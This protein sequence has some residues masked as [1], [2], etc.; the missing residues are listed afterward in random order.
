[1]NLIRFEEVRGNLG[2]LVAM[3]IGPSILGPLQQ[4][5]R[6]LRSIREHLLTPK[7]KP[8]RKVVPIV[9]LVREVIA[10]PIPVIKKVVVVAVPE[11][12]AEEAPYISPR[13]RSTSTSTTYNNE[14]SLPYK[15]LWAKV[16][17]RA[18]YDYALWRNS[19]DIRLRRFAQ[20]AER[21]LFESDQNLELSFENI[22]FHFDFP[23]EK[24]RKKTR[25]LTRDDVKKL[26][27]RERQGRSELL[28]EFS[29]GN[30]K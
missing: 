25:T 21:W 20:D 13:A 7:P 16:I 29:G 24:I 3:P 11:P 18:A 4:A 1:M 27:F 17:I 9:P 19:D 28:G 5:L 30:S 8:L 12:E 14:L 2:I 26:E 10:K 15:V 23:V 6:D 22:C